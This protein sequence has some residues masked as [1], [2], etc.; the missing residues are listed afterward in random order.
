M[1][2]VPTEDDVRLLEEQLR[3][4]K[5]ASLL[6]E[7]AALN[8]PRPPVQ[9]T[10]PSGHSAGSANTPLPGSPAG[11]PSILEDFMETLFP[12]R[13]EGGVTLKRVSSV[14]RPEHT[15]ETL[16]VVLQDEAE[17]QTIAFTEVELA[18]AAGSSKAARKVHEIYLL[19]I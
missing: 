11:S 15:P 1:A 19:I 10:V 17:P 3:S 6:K 2:M 16:L 8:A 9:A 12:C 18:P 13:G 7:L 14:S 5:H 4:A